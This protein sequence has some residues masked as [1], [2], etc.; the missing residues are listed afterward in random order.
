MKYAIAFTDTAL[1]NLKQ[2]RKC[3]QVKTLKKIVSLIAELEEHPETGTGHPEALKGDKAGFW[4]RAID[5]KNRLIYTINE[6]VVLVTVVS[7]LGHYNDK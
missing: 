5:K 6:D 1:E 4:S 7:M 2:W 3:G